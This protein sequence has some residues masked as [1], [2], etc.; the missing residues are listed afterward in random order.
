MVAVAKPLA[1]TD[2]AALTQ[3]PPTNLI[4]SNVHTVERQDITAIKNARNA[5]VPAIHSH[6]CGMKQRFKCLPS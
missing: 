4:G 5:K 6:A 3:L 2:V 1:N